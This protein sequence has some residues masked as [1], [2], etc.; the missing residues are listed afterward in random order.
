MEYVLLYEKKYNYFRADRPKETYGIDKFQFEIKELTEGEKF[1][2]NG[3]DVTVFKKG[4]W[5]ISKKTP[6]IDRLKEAWISGSIYS[7]TGHGT[8][9]KR[10]VEP[11]SE[12][13]RV[14]KECKK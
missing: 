1:Q 14:G 9:Y 7:D 4:E 12:E 3:R 10:V 8:M 5:E 6:D 13:R 11:R 2:A